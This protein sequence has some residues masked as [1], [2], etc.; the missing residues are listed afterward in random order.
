M[1]KE[2]DLL[3]R[4]IL[5]LF[6]ILVAFFSFLAAF[7]FRDI[8]GDLKPMPD[9]LGVILVFLFAWWMALNFFGSCAKVQ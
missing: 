7:K 8:L 1:I 4:R 5:M 9:Y 2:K 6:D 3:L